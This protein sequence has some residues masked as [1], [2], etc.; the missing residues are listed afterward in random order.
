MMCL[1]VSL[2][3]VSLTLH[4][5]TYIHTAVVVL[6]RL[7]CVYTNTCSEVA[8]VKVHGTAPSVC[9]QRLFMGAITLWPLL[10][11][12][13]CVPGA[14]IPPHSCTWSMCPAPLLYVEHVPHPILCSHIPTR[15]GAC[16]PIQ[17]PSRDD[18]SNHEPYPQELTRPL[19]HPSRR[20][21]NYRCSPPSCSS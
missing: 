15:H 12:P 11:P 4:P 18:S 8:A 17:S 9:I 21:S 6:C 14:C 13:L 20:R 5:Y 2:S 16:T 7:H 1:F 3:H 19:L 10:T